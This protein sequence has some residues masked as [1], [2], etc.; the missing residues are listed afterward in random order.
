MKLNAITFSGTRLKDFVDIY[1]LLERMSL[2]EM[3][4]AFLEKYEKV[5]PYVAAK[6]LNYFADVNPA[7]KIQVLN[8]S[9]TV[10]KM[11]D[12]LRQAVR[13]EEQVFRNN[14]L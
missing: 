5:N 3:L 14:N 8:K 9:F 4:N 13:N 10:E 2:K 6:A 1:F 7:E 11:K 12:R